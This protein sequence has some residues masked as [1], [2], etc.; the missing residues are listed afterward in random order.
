MSYMSAVFV[1]RHTACAKWWCC[2][3]MRVVWLGSHVPGCMGCIT[4]VRVYHMCVLGVAPVC[5]RAKRS[6]HT[7]IALPMSVAT[8]REHGGGGGGGGQ[9][10]DGSCVRV[11]VCPDVHGNVRTCVCVCVRV[12]VWGGGVTLHGW[13]AVRLGGDVSVCV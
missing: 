4:C 12:C 9:D 6:L 13:V 11:Y 2:L 8:V 3:C 7:L 10:V 5:G 1:L